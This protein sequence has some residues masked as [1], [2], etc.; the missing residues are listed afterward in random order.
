MT[1]FD[2]IT[3]GS[4]ICDI[5]LKSS[6]FSPIIKDGR[7]WFCHGYET[8]L[9]VSEKLVVSGGGGTNTAVS[10]ARAGLLTA[11]A[12]RLGDDLFANLIINEL[13]NE[14]V[15][16]KFLVQKKEET[17][18]SVILVDNKG[19]QAVLVC[20]GKTRLS[21]EDIDWRNLNAGW[22]YITSLEGN[23][24]LVNDLFN[25]AIKTGTKLAWNPGA[26]ELEQKKRVINL[27]SKTEVFNL[28]RQEMEKLVAIK[29]EDK[30]FWRKVAS[31]GAKMTVVTD[32][33]HGAYLLT[34]EG[35][36]IFE[37]APGTKPVDET[38]AGDAFGS[39]FVTGLIKE[40]SLKKA[41]SLAMANGASVVRYLGAKRGLRKWN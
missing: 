41:F 3:F 6:N 39:G 32:G 33:K 27:A 20:R 8:K 9:D 28:N 22:F 16:T 10:F 23:L 14:N 25:F 18:L 34:K 38:G 17:D 15:S 40:L 36:V 24:S 31:I 30:N 29:F 2:I 26:K 5:F 12:V 7:K 35:G 13:N 19:G 37:P 4:A 11:A 1:K 21:K